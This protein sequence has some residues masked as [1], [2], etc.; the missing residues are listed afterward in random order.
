MD[1]FWER[2]Y[3]HPPQL[4]L[5]FRCYHLGERDTVIIKNMVI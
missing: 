1:R 5:I 2:E 3:G 4:I